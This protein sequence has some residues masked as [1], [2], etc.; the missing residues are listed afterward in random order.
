MRK[1][2]LFKT[3]HLI[4]RLVISLSLLSVFCLHVLAVIDIKVLSQL[5]R[6]A[7]DEKLRLTMPGTVDERIVIVDIDEKSLTAEGQ[8]PWTRD[9]LA[10]LVNQLFD[11][12]GVAIAGFDVVFAE[13]NE[14]SGLQLLQALLASP[15]GQ[16][17]NYQADLAALRPRLETDRAFAEA[18]D[19]RQVVMGYVFKHYASATDN[20]LGQLPPASNTAGDL[21]QV[22]VV[23]AKGYTANLGLLQ[24]ATGL[25]GF[26]DNP[27]VDAD[28][29]FRRA[30]LLQRYE[31]QLYES[32]SLRLARL[33]LQADVPEPVFVDE[34]RGGASLLGVSLGPNIITTDE[35]LGILVPYR[36][37]QGSFQ[38]VSATDVLNGTADIEV[39]FD[40][41]VLVGSSAPGLLDLRATP[42][43][44][45]F[46]GVE[47]HANMIS[48]LLDG[49]IKQQHAWTRWLQSLLLALYAVAF[50]LLLPRLAP[51]ID[52]LLLLVCIAVTVALSLWFWLELDIVLELAVPV[53]FLILLFLLQTSY[54]LFVE[55]RRKR[56]LSKMFSQYVPP[57]LVEELDETEVSLEG[58]ARN[59]TVL[60]SDVRGFTSMSEGMEATALTQL[61][62]AFL[63]PLTKVIHAQRGTID[64]YMGD[65]IMAFWGAPLPTDQHAH[66]AVQAALDMTKEAQQVSAGFAAKNWPEVRVGIGLNTGTMNVGNMGSEF[67]TAYTVLGDAVNLGA[68]LEGLTRVYG[69]DVIVSEYTK[70]AAP[71]F[72][73][74]RLDH[75]RVKGRDQPVA[76]FEPIALQANLAASKGSDEPS[77]SSS[78]SSSESATTKP[79]IADLLTADMIDSFHSALDYF[80]EQNWSAAEAIL[81]QLNQ[82][83][84]ELLYELYIARIATYREQPPEADWDGVCTFTSK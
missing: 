28:G 77:S 49:N 52:F 17:P 59:M 74:R 30:P 44:K 43:A 32:L 55:N 31:G 83:R 16:D 7:Y 12:Y 35:Q 63:T 21:S 27:L 75:V 82:Q 1:K 64:K 26:F 8:W 62:N 15:L 48:G 33:R 13:P 51:G 9:K 36:G 65:A 45:Q 80:A 22:P 84:P 5:E 61:M 66:L 78:S 6:F 50:A 38:Y 53:I 20:Q 23:V 37:T 73:Y 76:I 54:G 46:V 18:L 10:Q 3:K 4:W 19:R 70:M 2:S 68:R 24:N 57:E 56:H 67:R 69:V 29:V 58:E 71:D 42:V 25:G 81:V 14:T 41:I 79:A 11:Q 60:F 72:V 47:V 39:L 40:K 34:G